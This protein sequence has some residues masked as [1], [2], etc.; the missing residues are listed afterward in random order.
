M[1]ATEKAIFASLIEYP[2]TRVLLELIDPKHLSTDGRE[3]LFS[4]KKNVSKEDV[5][6]Y[7]EILE[8]GIKVDFMDE[9]MTS[10]I[11]TERLIREFHDSCRAKDLAA[12]LGSLAKKVKEKQISKDEAIETVWNFEK[13]SK[14]IGQI[15]SASDVATEYISELDAYLK[16]DFIGIP[17]PYARLNSF[18]NPLGGG[19][20]VIVGGQAGMGKTAYM[21]NLAY[22]W[23]LKKI[24]VGFFALEMRAKEL[25]N[26]IHQRHFSFSLMRERKKLNIYKNEK[27]RLDRFVEEFRKLPLFFVDSGKSSL[28]SVVSQAKTMK[29]FHDVDVIFIDYLQLLRTEESLNRD[30]EIGLITRTLKLLAMELDIPVIIGSQLNRRTEMNN[31]GRPRLSNL[32]ESGNIEQDADI[33]QF[34]YRPFFY[35]NS[36]KE[37]DF[38]VIV[39]KQ[40]NGPLGTAKL[41]YDTERQLISE[42]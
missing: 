5:E 22:L 1:T 42:E 9:V 18:M 37:T 10:E 32:R 33:V 13:E 19:E 2:N 7:A 21:L 12:L 41:Y 6:I 15:K 17:F 29:L 4:I 28:V 34:V 38:E 27:E 3:V 20:L 30:G 26:R 40:R 14:T 36:A 24:R 25:E 16:G 35:V 23:A 39:G 31:D 8:K 11:A